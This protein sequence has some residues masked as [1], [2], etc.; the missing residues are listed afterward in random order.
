MHLKKREKWKSGLF[1]WATLCRVSLVY[2][3]LL[4][5]SCHRVASLCK[6]EPCR[7]GGTCHDQF[8]SSSYT[9]TCPAKFN[10]TNCETGERLLNILSTFL[11]SMQGFPANTICF[12]YCV[13]VYGKCIKSQ[14]WSF[15]ILTSGS[16]HYNSWEVCICKTFSSVSTLGWPL[17]FKNFAK[18]LSTLA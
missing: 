18:I 15:H 1:Y 12:L 10:G 17:T 6:S 5:C 7:N 9:C 14:K 2:V 4:L 3:C 8:A 13:S 16:N 11:Y